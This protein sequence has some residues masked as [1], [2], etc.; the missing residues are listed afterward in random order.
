MNM[1]PSPAHDHAHSQCLLWVAVRD[2]GAKAKI[3]ARIGR[4]AFGNAG[5]I[6]PAG[7]GV[8]ELRIHHGPGYQVYLVQR[9]DIL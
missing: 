3:V 5:D 1:G 8:S 6:A 4:L 2:A 9:G 7:E